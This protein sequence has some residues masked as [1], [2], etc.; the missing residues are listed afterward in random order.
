MLFVMQHPARI[1]AVFALPG[2]EDNDLDTAEGVLEES[3]KKWQPPG[4]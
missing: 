1:E 4:G 2:S 3:A